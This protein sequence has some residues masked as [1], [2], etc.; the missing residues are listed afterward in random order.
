MIKKISKT[1]ISHRIATGYALALGIAM[2][3]TSLGLVIGNYYQ[4]QARRE[5]ILASQE[6]RVLNDL[7][8][9]FLELRSQDE[10]LTRLAQTPQAYSYQYPS[11]QAR[12]DKSQILLS[13][14]ESYVEKSYTE[15]QNQT[16]DLVR[17][18]EAN[19]DVASRYLEIIDRLLAQ[20]AP[21]TVEGATGTVNETVLNQFAN[22]QNS[23][24][25]EAFSENLTEL[26]ILAH[27]RQRAAE[28]QLNQAE[29]LRLGIILIS[30]VLSVVI[31]VLLAI[32]TSRAITRPIRSAVTE[33]ASFSQQL[34]STTEEQ[35]R[36]AEQQA[37]TVQQTTVT[38]DEMGASSHQSAEQAELAATTAHDTLNLSEKGNKVAS[39]T[40]DGMME[41]KEKVEAIANKILQLNQQTDEINSITNLVSEIA[42]QT[43]MLALN[44]S[45]EA[46]RAGEQGKG[47]SVIATEIRKLADIS[48]E[49]TK[50]INTLLENITTEIQS[51]VTVTQAGT[52]TVKV[53]IQL[54]KDT[55]HIFSTVSDSVENIATNNQQI[56]LTAKQQLTA[57]QQVVEAMNSINSGA[58]QT[59]QGI[60]QTNI[61][62]E[63]LNEAAQNLQVLV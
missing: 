33:F 17:F 3:G 51:T 13:K 31:A 15:Q 14:F 61:S 27:Q 46:A 8:T 58:S 12:L 21:L 19:R 63:K 11:F 48:R 59:A 26:I 52:E 37:E 18:I 54:A 24:Q 6:A 23:V 5:Q 42:N 49:S 35:E 34:S 25:L 60:S 56:L 39:E 30:M 50:K 20:I 38:M 28:T 29:N 2:L 45:V 32:Y 4:N 9:A 57:V 16:E 47:F 53:G 1:R 22:I 10:Q 43:N 55:S 36:M 7:Q 44:A 62:S 40:L 41:L